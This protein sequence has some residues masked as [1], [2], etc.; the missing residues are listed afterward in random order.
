VQITFADGV[1][2]VHLFRGGLIGLNLYSGELT[3]GKAAETI[4]RRNV[5]IFVVDLAAFRII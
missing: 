5:R 3:A 2:W 1:G 4:G